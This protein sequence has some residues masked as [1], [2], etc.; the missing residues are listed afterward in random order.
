MLARSLLSA[1]IVMAVANVSVAAENTSPEGKKPQAASAG[2]AGL[3]LVPSEVN[4]LM[5][6]R[7]KRSGMLN[8]TVWGKPEGR[9]LDNKY[10]NWWLANQEMAAAL[11]FKQYDY[12]FVGGAG[13]HGGKHGGAIL[14]DSLRWLWREH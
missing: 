8:V 11:K 4:V 2:A 10:G 7:A 13:Q 3:A 5:A 14:P 12:K 6:D 9:D 1:V